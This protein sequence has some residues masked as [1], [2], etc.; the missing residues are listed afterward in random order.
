[1]K[2]K[3]YARFFANKIV[4]GAFDTQTDGISIRPLLNGEKK[5]RAYFVAENHG[6]FKKRYARVVCKGYFKF[7]YNR[8]MTDECLY[9]IS[10]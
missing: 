4:C 3:K 8:D 7:I 2:S 6:H 10:R 1:M 9:G 5:D